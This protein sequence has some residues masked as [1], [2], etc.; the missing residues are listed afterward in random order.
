MVG[1]LLP[2]SV[3]GALVNFAGMLMGKVPVN[4][5]YTVSEQTLASCIQQ[6]EIKTV[7]TSKAFLEKVRLKVPCQL[8][9]L[10][11]LAANPGL[12]EKLA[13]FCMAWMLP[14]GGGGA[15]VGAREKS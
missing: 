9:L 2:P 14:V 11:E 3:P 4:L 1:L 8:V 15:G 5:N 6:C 13:A 7:V 10:E 12:G